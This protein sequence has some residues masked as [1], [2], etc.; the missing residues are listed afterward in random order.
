MNDYESKQCQ[1]ALL[2]FLKR[3]G[4]DK[5]KTIEKQADEEFKGQ[6]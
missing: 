5:A 1:E 3:T 4:E 2:K 6:K